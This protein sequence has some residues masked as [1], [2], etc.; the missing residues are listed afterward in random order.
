MKIPEGYEDEFGFH[1]GKPPKLFEPHVL[2]QAT[3][4]NPPSPFPHLPMGSPTM[5][6]SE[7]VFGCPEGKAPIPKVHCA[8]CNK[9]MGW[10]EGLIVEGNHF[11]SLHCFVL[12]QRKLEQHATWVAKIFK[13]KLL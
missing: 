9:E 2:R 4:V 3:P 8:Y 1:Y 11:E 13:K 5:D 7:A 12:Y 6:I 10:H